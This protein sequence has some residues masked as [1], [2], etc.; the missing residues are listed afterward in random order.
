MPLCGKT[1]GNFRARH[2]SVPSLFSFF[3]HGLQASI[4]M[5]QSTQSPAPA[6][7]AWWITP[8]FVATGR[9]K[10]I[11]GSIFT[12]VSV[13]SVSTKQ[14]SLTLGV[15]RTPAS[16]PPSKQQTDWWDAC[17]VYFTSPLK[18][19]ARWTVKHMLTTKHWH[20]KTGWAFS[21]LL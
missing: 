16:R 11:A 9:K 12:E 5:C 15:W 21:Y 6:R 19:P 13:T 10:N 3:P 17:F 1:V 14:M 18:P 8:L 4:L 20:F 7:A 2:P